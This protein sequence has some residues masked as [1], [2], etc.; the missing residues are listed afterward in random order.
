MRRNPSEDMRG[1]ILDTRTYGLAEQAGMFC[2]ALESLE[3][4]FSGSEFVFDADE[5]YE[6]FFEWR[7]GDVVAGLSFM[8]DR[9]NSG[10]FVNTLGGQRRTRVRSAMTDFHA[11]DAG[12]FVQALE[13]ALGHPLRRIRYP[14]MQ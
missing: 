2:D 9:D 3:A 10:W 13:E 4:D 5:P 7:F 8:A 6:V 1:C 11:A 12:M 14:I